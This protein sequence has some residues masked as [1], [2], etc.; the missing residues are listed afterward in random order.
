ML[1]RATALRPAPASRSLRCGKRRSPPDLRP[2]CCAPARCGSALVFA[3]EETDG[4]AASSPVCSA[5]LRTSHEARRAV[6]L[7]MDATKREVPRIARRG[8]WNCILQQ[9]MQ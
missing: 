3:E 5:C 8:R 6:G 7:A 4:P 2:P 1:P 9:G